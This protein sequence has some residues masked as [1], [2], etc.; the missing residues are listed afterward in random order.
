MT[1]RFE[2]LC[3]QVGLR[4]VNFPVVQ[5]KC[6]AYKNG[7]AREFN[8]VEAALEFSSN[9][10]IVCLNEDEI[11]EASK[12]FHRRFEQAK[13]LYYKELHTELAP[14]LSFEQ[15]KIVIDWLADNPPKAVDVQ[16]VAYKEVLETHL[17]LAVSLLETTKTKSI[18]ARQSFHD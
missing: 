11:A 15:F 8:T 13:D 3:Q 18:H 14:T 16:H 9:Y 6:Y 2:E 1:A 5:H 4:S 10:E 12:E 7:E 17:K